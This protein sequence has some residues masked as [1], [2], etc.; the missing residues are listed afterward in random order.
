VTIVC[1]IPDMKLPSMKNLRTHWSTL[2]KLTANQRLA[3]ALAVR[4]VT[5][6]KERTMPAVVTITRCA[7]RKIDSDNLARA[8]SAIRD[9][10]AQAWGVDD[11]NE[12]PKGWTWRY[13]QTVAKKATV[14]IEIET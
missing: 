5:M 4:S 14:R 6:K 1:E 3:A 2:A 11:G 9:G 8:C 10:I 13:G 12:G 7:P